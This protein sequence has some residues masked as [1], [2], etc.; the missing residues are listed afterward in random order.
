MISVS[1]NIP[2]EAEGFLTFD[3]VSK[4]LKIDNLEDESNT[5]IPIASYVVDITLDDDHGG[6]VNY[7][8]TLD[9]LEAPNREPEFATPLE[10]SISI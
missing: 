10:T 1:A 9:I 3:S 2:T 5:Y 6:I 7:S 8:I 4:E